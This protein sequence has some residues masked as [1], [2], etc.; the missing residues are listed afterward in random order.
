MSKINRIFFL[1]QMTG[2]LFR[3]LCIDAAKEFEEVC[4]LYTGHPDTILDFERNNHENLRLIKSVEYNRSSFLTRAS[5]WLMYSAGAFIRILFAPK[6]TLLFAVSNPPTLG[7]VTWLATRITRHKYIVLVYDIHPD[8]LV[9]FGKLS[10]NSIVTKIWRWFNRVVYQNSLGVYTIGEVMAKRLENNFDVKKTTLGKVGVVP[11]WADVNTLKPLNK[12]DN[13][14]AHEVECVDKVT[15]L[16]SGNMGISHDIES[17]LEAAR[18]L[19]DEDSINF[20]FIGEGQKWQYV[21]EKINQHNLRNVK[22]FPFQP[23]ERLKYTMTVGDISIVALD[24]GAE[25][26]MIPSKMYYYMASGAAI[27]GISTGDNELKKTIIDNN[28]GIVVEPGSAELLAD[29][30]L[31]LSKDKNKLSEYKKYARI[32][33]ERQYSR[34]VCTK[35]LVK[36]L[37]ILLKERNASI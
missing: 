33:A 13:V 9:Q 32:T 16:Y 20:I 24:K 6:D 26:L 21:L 7:I 18:I 10:S 8:T 4:T 5:S 25:G 35:K 14:F 31:T 3:E 2:P 28:I 19:S 11:P 23:E 12:S 34:E 22:I 36:E 30:I 27:V 1:N 37:K 17:M 15:V 29:G